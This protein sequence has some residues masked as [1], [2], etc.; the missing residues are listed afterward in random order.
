MGGR[1]IVAVRRWTALRR[2]QAT[3][4]ITIGEPALQGQPGRPRA[5]VAGALG[6]SGVAPERRRRQAWAFCAGAAAFARFDA[7]L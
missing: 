4:S 7:D 5:G 3:R 1:Q 6:R 2:A